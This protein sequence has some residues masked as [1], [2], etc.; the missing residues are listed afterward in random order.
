MSETTDALGTAVDAEHAAVYTY[1]VLTAFTTGAQRDAVATYIAEHRARRDELNQALV[2]AGAPARTTAPGY[3]IPLA[4]TNSAT[5]ARA[6][7]DAEQDTAQA[8]RSLAEHADTEKIRRLAVDGL[9]ECAL[10]AA[11]WREAAGIR[12]VTTALPGTR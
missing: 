9:T 2:A 4:V 10:R 6:A 7:L 8:Y 12:P 5:A 11:F 3:I 1:G